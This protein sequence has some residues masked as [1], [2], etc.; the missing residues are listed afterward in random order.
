MT[1]PRSLSAPRSIRLGTRG[2]PLALAQAH[3]IAGSLK[4]ASGGAI[5]AEIVTFT[6]TGD[7]L[8]TERLINSGGKGLFTRELDESLTRGDIDIAVHSLKDVPAQLPDGQ[9]FVAFPH[10]EDP[11][12]G[13]VSKKAASLHD[14]P[15]GARLG[16]ASLRREAQA[17]SL[18]PDLQVVTFRGN[19]QTRMRKLDEGLAD[20][21][22]L[23][24]AGLTR[25][26]YADMATPIP[27]E[28]MLPSA[29]QGIIGVVARDDADAELRAA[30]AK[31]NVAES[32]AAA[33]AERAFLTLLDGSCRTP[34]AAHLSDEG[35]HW[36]L[37]GEVLSPAGDQRWRATGTCRKDAAMSD[38]A[39]LGRNVA[40]EILESAQGKLP[41][42]GDE[43]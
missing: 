34:I 36:R 19:V 27:L 16:T 10:R 30:L 41:V 7:Q 25:L 22:F 29:A 42:F 5:T 26:G 13:F 28:D 17:L 15:K 31:L 32:E 24:M 6:T 39:A 14:L 43:R 37:T 9:V 11:R 4:D 38:L 1:E 20:A 2:S 23:A 35:A 21:T 18:R 33:T 8:T 40:G 12:D 3:Q